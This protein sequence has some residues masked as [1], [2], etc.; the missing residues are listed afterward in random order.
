MRV[1]GEAQ[2]AGNK[3]KHPI[4]GLLALTLMTIG[5]AVPARAEDITVKMS[6]VTQDGISEAIGTITITGSDAG[7]SFKL[8]LHGLAPGAH[9][10]HVHENAS[11]GPTLLN[12]IRIPAGAAG[13][14]FD[15][16]HAGKHDGPAGDGHFGDLPALEV[17]PN[18]TASQTLVAPRIKDVDALKGHALMIHVGGD[19]Y[20]D[21]PSALG[22]GGAR[23]ACGVVQ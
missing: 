3:M 4:D 22:G 17:E 19:N 23:F 16:D 2:P 8:G 6:K 21:T 18:G 15:P 13:G 7:A 9:G 10:F 1:S 20:K 12:G 14:H 11:C 5:L